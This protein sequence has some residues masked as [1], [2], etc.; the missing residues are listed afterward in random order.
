M[1]NA[2]TKIGAH[3]TTRADN[4]A[5]TTR[6]PKFHLYAGYILII[7]N[8]MCEQVHTTLCLDDEGASMC[9]TV[10]LWVLQDLRCTHLFK[11]TLQ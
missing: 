5:M 10:C 1:F 2:Y 4:K 8:G 11:K 9:D 3:K 6:A 7:Y